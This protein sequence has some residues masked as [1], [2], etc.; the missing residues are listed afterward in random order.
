MG[1]SGPEENTGGVTSS[2]VTDGSP[3]ARA[4]HLQFMT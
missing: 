3:N 1:K 2:S 4:V